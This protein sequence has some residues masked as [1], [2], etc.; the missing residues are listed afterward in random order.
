M[1]PKL[2]SRGM[3]ET[4]SLPPLGHRFGGSTTG[5]E[6]RGSRGLQIGRIFQKV[7]L[8]PVTGQISVMAQPKPRRAAFDRLIGMLRGLLI[9]RQQGSP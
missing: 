9:K 3:G 1:I 4:P 2:P 6:F 8:N 7:N 5:T